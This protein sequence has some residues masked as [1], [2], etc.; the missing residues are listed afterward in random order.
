MK[1]TALK[2]RLIPTKEQQRLLWMHAGTR[3]YAYNF[4]KNY[5]ENYYKTHRK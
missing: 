4:A 3:R 1:Y 2:V 5:S